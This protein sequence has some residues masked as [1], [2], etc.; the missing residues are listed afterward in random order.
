MEK[1]TRAL[2]RWCHEICR[3][4]VHSKNGRLVKIEEDHTDPRTDPAF[5]WTKACP[6]LAAAHEYVYHPDRVR[7]PLKRAG[8]RGENKWQKITWE[9][10]LDEIAGKLEEIRKRYGPESLMIT[11]GTG[12]TTQWTR[13]RFSNLFGSPNYAGQGTVCFGPGLAPA[14]AMLGWVLSLRPR[15]VIKPGKDGRPMTKCVFVIG[16]NDAQSMPR[17]WKSL[18]DAKKAGVKIIAVDPRR[19]QTAEL[20]DIWLQPR[21]G[22]DAALLL[23]MINTIIEDE[24]YDKEFV[25]KW[26]YGFEKVAERAKEYPREKAAEI[27]WVPAEQIRKAAHLYASERP[28]VNIHGVGLEH[29]ENNQEAI[30]ANIIL[31]AILGNIDVEGGD[32]IGGVGGAAVDCIS[33]EEFELNDMLSSEQ[34]KKQIGADRFKLLSFPGRQLI[35]EYSKKLWGRECTLR[36]YANFP[37]VLRAIIT[38]KPYPVRAGITTYSNP[39]VTQANTKLVYKALKSL[40]L[41]IVND[42][43]LTPSALLADYVLPTTCWIERP[44]LEPAITGDVIGGEAALPAVISG[45]YEYRTDYEF[46]RGLG[47]RLGQEK[48]WPWRTLEEV[49]DYRLERMGMTFQEFMVENDGI[50]LQRVEYKK[51]EKMGGF[52]TPTGKLELYSTILEKLGYDPLPQYSEPKE[53]PFSTPELTKDYPFMLITGGRFQPYFHSEYRQIESIRKRRRD[54]Q[55]QIH[56]ETAQNLG[57]NNGDWVWIETLRGRIKQ[58]CL[59]FNGIQPGVVHAEHG[60]WFPELPGEEPSLGGVW[61]SNVN[62][63]T[64]DD[65]ER[66]N[67][68]SGGWPLRTS[69]CRVWKAESY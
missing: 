16:E 31:S 25:Q 17:S 20:A 22:T 19:T 14:A 21:P 64:D 46:F 51:Y 41:Y 1:V 10:A 59:Y 18:R 33:D 32:H 9:Q 12:R 24:L 60:W 3:V 27:T 54:P 7:F 15:I 4:T 63:L 65:P 56:P 61:K 39:M 57:I 23:S 43:W 29:L 6:R 58:R 35:S 62:V 67:P 42:F 28:G 66:C 53:S 5:P 8:E 38:G 47:I 2:C 69:L 36:S 50:H 13:I 40:D 30:Q 37:L 68:R 26:C 11:S 45:E 49:C 55:V 52:A 48:Y 44:Q 34:K